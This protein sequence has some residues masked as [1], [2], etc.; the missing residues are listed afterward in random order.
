MRLSTLVSSL[1]VAAMATVTVA[2]QR[3][4]AAADK[5]ISERLQH[6]E[7]QNNQIISML[8]HG[9]GARGAAKPQRPRPKPE[10]T[11]SVPIEGA[12]SV[13]PKDALVTV[14]EGFDFACPYCERARSTVDQIIQDYPKDV[15]VVYRNF[16]VHPQV[17]TTPALAACAAAQQGKYAEMNHLIWDKGYN[18]GRNLGAD[19]ME[20]LAKQVG[21]D[22]N[23]FRADMNGATCKHQL[24]TDRTDL[25]RVGVSG[26]PAFYVN[27]RFVFNR[28]T[29]AFKGL[30]DEELKKAKERVAQGTKPA[31]Y[32]KTWVVDKGQKTL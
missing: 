22:L 11:Y 12:P 9:A 6:L 29:S 10:V 7:E 23:R 15:R 4:D 17:A 3:D 32:Y 31:D 28:S 21:L 26:T 30:I 13:G 19:N 20:T 1:C 14:V 8:Q 25:A 18:A 5:S 2:C 24:Q 16:V 27:G